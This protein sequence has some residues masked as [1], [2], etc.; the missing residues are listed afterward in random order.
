MSSAFDGYVRLVLCAGN[1]FLKCTFAALCDRVAIA[2]RSQ[3]R[4]L[5]LLKDLPRFAIGL[6]GRVGWLGGHD[7]RKLPWPGFV[8]VVGKRSIV[9]CNYIRRQI[10]DASAFY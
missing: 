1:E 3:Q 5:P 4:L 9:G 8:A 7:Q 2:E 6:A 10:V